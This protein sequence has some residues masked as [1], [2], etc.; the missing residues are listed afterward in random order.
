MPDAGPGGGGGIDDPFEV[1]T[2]SPALT[3]PATGDCRVEAGTGPAVIIRGNVIGPQDGYEHGEVVYSGD[4]IVCTGCDC[5]DVAGYD[6]ATVI[7]CPNASISAALVNPHDHIRFTEG[8]PIDTGTQRYQH[9]HDWRGSLSTPQ[10]PHGVS[11]TSGGMRWGELRML[12]SGTASMVGSG[13]ADGLIRNLDELSTDERA[14][15]LEQAEYTTFSLGD[16]NETYH[17]N[18]E[19]NYAY[20]EAE[21][22]EFPSFIPHV[23]EGIN[24]VAGEEFRCQSRSGDGAQDFTEGNT[25]HIHAIGL[26]TED[27][28]RMARDRA[29]IIWSP[30]SNISLYGF[31][32]QVTT[33]KRFGG[34]IALG[35]DWTYS[36]SANTLRELACADQYNRNNLGGFFSDKQLHDM[37]TINGAIATGNG[38][39]LGSLEVGKLADIAIFAAKAE[40]QFHRNV[41]DADNLSTLLVIR[42]GQPLYGRPAL[43]ESLGESCDDLTVCGESRVVCSTREFGTSFAELKGLVQGADD[44]AYDAIFCEPIPAGEPTCTPIRVGEFSGSPAQG[45]R[46]GD[47]IPD[48]SDNCPDVFNAIRPI[49][50]GVQPDADGDGIGDPCDSDPLIADLDGD[51]KDNDEDNCPFDENATQTDGDN[52]GRGDACDSCPMLANPSTGCSSGGSALTTTITAVQDGTVAED[53][54]VVIENVVVTGI[55]ANDFT[56]QDPGAGS[57]QYSG[58]LVF[59]GSDPGVSVGDVVDVA[60][61]TTEFFGNTEITDATVTP[62]GMTGSITATAVSVAEA[63]SEPY[64]NVLVTVSTG[65]VT[66][67]YNCSV[68]DAACTDQNLWALSSGGATVVVYDKLYQSG[69]W[70]TQKGT[71][72]VTGV[73]MFRRNSWRLMPRT[74]GD[75]GN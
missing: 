19:W 30:R 42:G 44:P 48:G 65:S 20:D 16:S 69:D 38:G 56:V 23:A 66:D 59:L 73:T 32:A 62:K 74:S 22:A 1:T 55:G 54:R 33:F 8:A 52:D 21:V 75:F 13:G 40:G 9:R 14:R 24:G 53:T 35:T 10:N 43:V 67:P 50:D 28:M 12:F 49:D 36:G 63:A 5:S 61:R 58:V 25:A 51:G 7:E 70:N 31:T 47:G 72:P 37:A 39:L 45:D 57:A 4:E 68:D 41:I 46:D 17:P 60:G 27:Y 2:C 71:T 3:P 6:E 26:S 34:T 15:G 29:Q 18:C 11:A 64:E